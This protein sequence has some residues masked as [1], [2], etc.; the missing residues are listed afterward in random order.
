MATLYTDLAL[1]RTVVRP[2]AEGVEQQVA[3][4][5]TLP[6]GTQIALNDV[7]NLFILGAGVQVTEIK[8]ITD[9]LDD[10][11]TMTWDV[12]Y[13]QLA[14]GTGYAGTNS[15]GVSTDFDIETGT[16]GTSPATDADYYVNDATFGQAAGLSTLTLASTATGDTDGLAGPVQV[17]ATQVAAT[18]T[19]STVDDAVRQVTFIF[20]YVRK[21]RTPVVDIDR[22]GY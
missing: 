3:A 13:A 15:S 17:T 5:L 22:G 18:P 6:I 11:T 19:Q 20:K 14:P 9:D 7:V 10:G 1:K 8:V 4:T 2:T 16:T 12:G 21:S